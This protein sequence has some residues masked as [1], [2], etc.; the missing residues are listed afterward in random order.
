MCI[1]YFYVEHC[2]VFTFVLLTLKYTSVYC[3]LLSINVCIVY[4]YLELGVLFTLM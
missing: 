2:I 4:L 1:V 3:L